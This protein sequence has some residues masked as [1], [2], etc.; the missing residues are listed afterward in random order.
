MVR[1]PS[2]VD[3]AIKLL[4][5][6]VLVPLAP[7]TTSVLS[8]TSG[9]SSPSLP[10]A[11][12]LEPIAAILDAFESH[13]VVALGESHNEP[14]VHAVRLALIHHPRFPQVVDDVV[15]ESGGAQLQ[16]AMDRFV[17][18]EEM[19]PT[20]LREVASTAA[21]TFL[22]PMYED[23]PRAVQAHN[24]ELSPE[25]QIRIVLGEAPD[26][27]NRDAFV[28]EVIRR[29]V[30]AKRR[31]ALVIYGNMHLLRRHAVSVEEVEAERW[32]VDRLERLG[33]E[34]FS[35]WAARRADVDLPRL[36]PSAARW[37]LPALINVKGTPLG[38]ADFAFYHS[39]GAWRLKDGKP[40]LVNGSPTY[41][42]PRPGL[43]MEEQ[44]DAVLYLGR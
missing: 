5:L 32:M 3:L 24:R 20:F 36:Q 12:P 30:V 9:R 8:Q 23:I 38:V 7:G 19:S 44:V 33:I 29:E 2:S 40:I 43:R 21:P 41:D 39:F 18:G 22:N 37:R 13:T 27:R 31:R 35:I 15:I 11:V 14:L 10:E 42:P 4:L 28:T 17:R 6:A 34:V 1:I 16:E 26:H 25:H